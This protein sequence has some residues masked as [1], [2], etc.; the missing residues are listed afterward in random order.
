MEAV[1]GPITN[2][3]LKWGATDL[4]ALHIIC[5]ISSISGYVLIKPLLRWSN[6]AQLMAIAACS[7]SPQII[8]SKI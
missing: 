4:A 2:R 7:I 1:I 3:Y 8:L 6:Q 5:G